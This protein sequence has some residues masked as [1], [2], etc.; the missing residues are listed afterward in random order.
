MKVQYAIFFRRKTKNNY[1]SS[2][3]AGHWSP[4]CW[5]AK[6]ALYSLSYIPV[7]KN[8]RVGLLLSRQL[9][10]FFRRKSACVKF[11]YAI[12]F[13]RRQTAIT[14]GLRLWRCRVFISESLASK[15]SYLPFGISPRCVKLSRRYFGQSSIMIFFAIGLLFEWSAKVFLQKAKNNY[16]KSEDL[17][18]QGLHLAF[19]IRFHYAIVFL[20]TAKNI[21]GR[22][23]DAGHWSPNCWHAKRALYSLSYIPVAKNYRVGLL[24]SRQLWGFFRRKSASVKFQYAIVFFQKANSI[25]ARSQV[26]EMQG[27]H[28]RISGK[29]SERSTIRDLSTLCKTIA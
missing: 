21:K 18:M 5:H 3:D 12:V 29:Q 14:Q 6:R 22:T 8:Y 9:W 4:N 20:Q 25:Y 2:G 15:A 26:M 17:E 10:G 28:L 1:G 23:G 19:G 7:A 13:F 27:L 11:Q 24:L 16:G